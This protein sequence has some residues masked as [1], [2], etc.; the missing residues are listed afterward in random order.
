MLLTPK[1]KGGEIIMFYTIIWLIIW[2]VTGGTTFTFGTGGAF[3]GLVIAI[4]ADVFYFGFLRRQ[5]W[6]VK[7]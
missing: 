6:F 1:N 4:I 3:W 2:L 7:A 5:T